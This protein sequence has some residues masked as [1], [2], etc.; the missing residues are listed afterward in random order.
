LDM[1]SVVESVRL[2]V[3]RI[4]LVMIVRRDWQLRGT[5]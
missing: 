4:D 3:C 1:I 5:G 2:L